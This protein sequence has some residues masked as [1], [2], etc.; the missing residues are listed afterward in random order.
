MDAV[1]QG[2]NEFDLARQRAAQQSNAAAQAQKDALKR[3]F[4]AQ[5]NVNSGSFIKSQEQVDNNAQEKLQQANEGINAQ[6]QTENRRVKEIQDNRDFARSERLGSQDFSAS[7]ADA[8]RRFQTGERTGGEQFQTGLLGKQQDFAA[9]Q[10]EAQRKYATGERLSS[11]DFAALQARD[12]RDFEGHENYLNRVE[13]NTDR[14]QQGEQFDRQLVLDEWATKVNAS[15]AQREANRPTGLIP[16]IVGEGGVGGMLGGLTGG[17]GGGGKVICT[18]YC[19]LG[20]LPKEILAADLEY[21]KLH[22]SKEAIKN[23]LAW[24]EYVVPLIRT[25]KAARHLFWPISRA[26]AYQMAWRMGVVSKRPALGFLFETVF[27]AASNVVGS[28]IRGF[29]KFS[30]GAL[31]RR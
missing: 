14:E 20:W 17:G 18:E 11:Q 5:G 9:A 25:N 16:G 4:A 15:M 23:Y 6:Q 19:R 8:M 30:E 26:W 2:P 24:A 31:C 21:Q 7:Q 3:R 1:D 13:H 10:A 27:L 29:R 22:T 28:T 12:A